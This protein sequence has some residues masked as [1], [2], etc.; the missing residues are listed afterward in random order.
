MHGSRLYVNRFSLG[1]LR[2][3]TTRQLHPLIIFFT[4][5]PRWHQ[6]SLKLEIKQSYFLQGLQVGGFYL[7]PINCCRADIDES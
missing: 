4:A 3:K 1:H 7:K 6:V 5:L 2:N